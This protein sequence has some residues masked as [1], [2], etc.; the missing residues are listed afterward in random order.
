[1]ASPNSTVVPATQ[2]GEMLTEL[3]V[4]GSSTGIGSWPLTYAM[5]K[6]LFEKYGLKVDYQA[7]NFGSDAVATILAGGADV[8][9]VSGAAVVNA[10]LVDEQPVIVAGLISRQPYSLAVT[11]DVKNAG[12]LRGKVLAVSDFGGITETVLR[13]TLEEVGLDPDS[14]VTLV[15]GGSDADRLAALQSGQIAGAIFSLLTLGKVTREGFHV[16][17]ETD[18]LELPIQHTAVVTTRAF[19]ADNRTA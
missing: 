14:D 16:L 8:C 19:L 6:G 4:C 3:R 10:A 2:A 15:A 17:Q 12:D 5:N 9:Q 7:V 13:A 18:A 11:A 1:M